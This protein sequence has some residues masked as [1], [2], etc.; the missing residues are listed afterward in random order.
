MAEMMASEGSTALVERPE[1]DRSVFV[2]M[3]APD[4]VERARVVASLDRYAAGYKATLAAMAGEHRPSYKRRQSTRPRP[5]KL[6]REDAE[7]AALLAETATLA[8]VADAA[9]VSIPCLRATWRRHGITVN[10][11]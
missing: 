10:R 1:P 5:V 6:T 11:G 4:V 9:G 7:T 2:A 3:L 8:E